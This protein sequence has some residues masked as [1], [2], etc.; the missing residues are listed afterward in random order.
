MRGNASGYF[1]NIG[2]GAN[3]LK[4]HA[5]NYARYSIKSFASMLNID[6]KSPLTHVMSGYFMV[7]CFPRP[8]MG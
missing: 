7:V 1:K 8:I 5:E 2:I 4:R 6:F 3:P